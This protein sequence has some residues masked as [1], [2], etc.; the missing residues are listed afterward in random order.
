MFSAGAFFEA[1][2]FST[3]LGGNMGF[4]SIAVRFVVYITLGYL[5]DSTCVQAWNGI[6]AIC[7]LS[8][9]LSMPYFVRNL[10]IISS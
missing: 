5:S 9:A 2:T 7:D 1:K 8:I 6:G 4:A 10:S 3:L